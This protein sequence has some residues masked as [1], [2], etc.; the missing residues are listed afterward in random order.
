[1][2]TIFGIIFTS[3]DTMV[4]LYIKGHK[5]S[6]T[7]NWTVEMR[8]RER[9]YGLHRLL[10]CRSLVSVLCGGIILPCVS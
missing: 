10:R 8:L 1:M 3:L 6:R 7:Y 5:V 4:V 9:S 2:S